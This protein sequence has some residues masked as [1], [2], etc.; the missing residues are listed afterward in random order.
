MNHA[1]AGFRFYSRWLALFGVYRIDVS[2]LDA[3]CHSPPIILAPNHPSLID[4]PLILGCHPNLSCI[5]K[6]GLT[7]NLLFGP[8]APLARYICNRSSLQMVRAAID[9][10]RDGQCCCCSRRERALPAH[11]SISSKRALA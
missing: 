10:L 7:D 11:R 6:S 9:N 5:I 3:L 4:A 8:G 1:R 2:A